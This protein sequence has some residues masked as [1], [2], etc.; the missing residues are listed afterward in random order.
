M[1]SRSDPLLNPRPHGP[2][3]YAG[4]PT[5]VIYNLASSNLTGTTATVSWNV[6]PGA[7]GQVE[8]G[9]TAAYGSVSTLETNFLTGHVQNLSALSAGTTYHYRVHSVDSGGNGAYSSDQTFLTTGGGVSAPAW[10]Q[11]QVTSGT[12]TLTGLD[13]TGATDMLSAIQSQVDASPNARVVQFPAGTL[14][15]SSAINYHGRSHLRFTAHPSGTTINN[16]ANANVG[17]S[18]LKSTFFTRFSET[19]ADHIGFTG[20]NITAASPSQGVFQSGEFAAALGAQKGSYI[21]FANNTCT[22]LF[23][24]MV[25]LNENPDHVWIHENNVVNCGRHMLS[26]ICA[27]TVMCESNTMGVSG[28]GV[29]DIEPEPGSVAGALSITFRDNTI[30]SY[31]TNTF[32]S[33]NGVNANKPVQDIVVT[34]NTITGKALRFYAIYATTNRIQR[35]TVSDNV[36]HSSLAGPIFNFAHIDG[37]TVKNNDQTHTGTL[38]SESDNT[39]KDISGNTAP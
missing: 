37:L 30:T 21:E 31:G 24:D 22:G 9:L 19:A 16:V 15:I 28:Y 17:D 5:P 38:I 32:V 13:T 10:W 35:L 2:G 3:P 6:A 1:L 7:T 29:F 27:D 14:K 8:Y 11:P 34:G 12:T 33:L 18:N 23:G 25:T 36:S 39:L 20:F 26:V 4:D